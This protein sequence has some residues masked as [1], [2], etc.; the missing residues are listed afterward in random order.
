MPRKGPE[1]I[2]SL[3]ASFPADDGHRVVHHLF[4]RRAGDARAAAAHARALGCAVEILPHGKDR[5]VEV[6]YAAALLPET[7]IPVSRALAAIA[8]RNGGDYGGWSGDWK[9]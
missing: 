1:R 8:R 3:I 6:T 4:F 7:T 2:A 5:C 9:G